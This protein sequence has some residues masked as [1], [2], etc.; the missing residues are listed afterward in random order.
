MKRTIITAMM[1]TV[2]AAGTAHAGGSLFVDDSGVTPA[3][4]C[5]LESWLRA[6]SG[7]GREL[8]LSP[9]CSAGPLE[10]SLGL[11]RISRPGQSLL[12]PGLKWQLRDNS[13]GGFGLA[14]ATTGIYQHGKLKQT[15]VYV[16]PAWA[17]GADQQ[18]QIFTNLGLSRDRGEKSKLAGGL[19]MQYS[20]SKAVDLVAERY[21]RKG[22]DA[23]NEAGISFNFGSSAS[24]DLL[25]GKNRTDQWFTFGYNVVF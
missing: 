25:V 9:A 14:V 16:A 15:D 2:V 19:G 1:A 8:T 22:R 6:F 18:W 7:G 24:I 3:G 4:R 20:L 17:L 13:N 5:Q 23:T 10:F 12:T 21:I 11:T